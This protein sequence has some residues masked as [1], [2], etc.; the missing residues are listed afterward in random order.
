LL[1]SLFAGAPFSFVYLFKV[2]GAS[3]GWV[4]PIIVV[5]LG[6]LIVC[7]IAVGEGQSS[8]PI[9]VTGT[10]LITIAVLLTLLAAV[11]AASVLTGERWVRRNQLKIAPNEAISRVL[12]YGNRGISS[13]MWLPRQS[14][15]QRDGVSP[16][17]SL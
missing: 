9:V 3:V 14:G 13:W 12:P 4:L 1:I 16:A 7:S 15:V 10:W 5:Y 17:A 11:I 6:S 2:H 8:T